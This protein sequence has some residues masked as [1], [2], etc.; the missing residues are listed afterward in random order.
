MKALREQLDQQRVAAAK[1]HMAAWHI[2]RAW[3]AYQHSAA[4]AARHAQVIALQAA[5]RGAAARRAAGQLK[6]RRQILAE[7]QEA[8]RKGQSAVVSSAQQQAFDAG[9]A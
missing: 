3:R 7:L 8:L 6:Q 1:R 5:I 4:R 2:A 9:R